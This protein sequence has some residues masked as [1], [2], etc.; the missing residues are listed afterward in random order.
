MSVALNSFRRNVKT[1][2]DEH[3]ITLTQMAAD[4][5]MSRPGLSRVIHGHDG[6]TLDRAEKIA[7]YLGVSLSDLI[8]PGGVKVMSHSA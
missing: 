3:Q 6:V 8:Q 1:L 4:I 5:G 2:L 7:D